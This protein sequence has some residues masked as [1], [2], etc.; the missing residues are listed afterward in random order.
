MTGPTIRVLSLGAGVQSTAVA[1]LAARGD[2]PALD[3]AIFSDTGWEP[4]VVYEHLARLD[5]EVLRPAG[6]PLRRVSAGNIRD[7]ALDPEHRFASMPLYVRSPCPLCSGSGAVQDYR[8]V[9]PDDPDVADPWLLRIARALHLKPRES[10][11]YTG[12]CPCCGGSGWTSGMARRQCTSEYKLKPI[13]REVRR[14]LGAPPRPDGIPGRVPR[15]RW[16]EQWVGIS[17]DESHRAM[18]TISVSYTRPRWPLLELGL[19]RS[20]CD[21]INAAAGF[22]GTPKSACVGCPF[23]A[24]RQ[25]REMRD[26]RPAEWEDACSF[27]DAIR[28]GSARANAQ[29]HELRGQA[30]LHR[31]RTPLRDAPIDH[32]TSAEH[33]SRQG[34]LLD[35]ARAEHL[36]AA[37]ES[38]EPITGCSPFMCR[39]DSPA[40][41]DVAS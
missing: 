1:I 7:D 4:A 30:F 28:A 32:V 22:P 26:E 37:V 24:N 12:S 18:S 25:W 11:S 15:G 19:S 39:G 3:A 14:L 13:T 10:R 36:T 40:I 17:S 31:S 33:R 34:D 8:V 38:E 23:H 5:R 35:L 2:L 27:D 20:D 21:A 9:H 41:E 16:A 29:G 6:I